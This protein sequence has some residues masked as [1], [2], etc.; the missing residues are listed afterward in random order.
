M[1][2]VSQTVGQAQRVRQRVAFGGEPCALSDNETE[3]IMA[4]MGEV[5]EAEGLNSTIRR[6]PGSALNLGPDG[7]IGPSN[8]PQG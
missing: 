1:I 2:V 8:R 5:I 6:G 4:R 7:S 3:S